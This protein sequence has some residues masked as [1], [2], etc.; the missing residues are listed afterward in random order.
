MLPWPHPYTQ[1]TKVTFLSSAQLTCV[2][3]KAHFHSLSTDDWARG[4]AFLLKAFSHF[5]MQMNSFLRNQKMSY[6]CVCEHVWMKGAPSVR[7]HTSFCMPPTEAEHGGNFNQGSL[8]ASWASR[9][10]CVCAC[11]QVGTGIFE[12]VSGVL[13]WNIKISACDKE[14][15]SPLWP[16]SGFWGGKE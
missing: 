4:K 12:M 2:E 3:K 10:D 7:G 11:V 8:W 16:K 14:A 6:V 5:L 1:K 15:N 9:G 13:W